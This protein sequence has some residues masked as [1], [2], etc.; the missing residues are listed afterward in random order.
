MRTFIKLTVPASLILLFTYAAISKLLDPDVFR[1]Q[2]YR[3]PFSHALADILLY[4]LPLSES[5]AIVLLLFERTRFAG[6]LFS[7]GL[8]LVFSC[9]ISLGLLRFWSKIPC[10]CGGIL[11]HL[12]WG[13]HLIFNCAFL[14]AAFTGIFAHYMESRMAKHSL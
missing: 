7:A 2:L 5:L 3:Q 1:S 10:S 4:A 6:L 14:L 11:N 9:Y 8:L 12:S 13:T